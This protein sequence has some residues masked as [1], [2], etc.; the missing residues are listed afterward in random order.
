MNMMNNRQPPN[1]SAGWFQGAPL[2]KFVCLSVI[3][4]HVLLEK[5]GFS[6]G[7]DLIA[8]GELYVILRIFMYQVCFSMFQQN[9]I[10]SAC[11]AGW[12]YCRS[13]RYGGASG[14]VQ[15][16]PISHDIQISQ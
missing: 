15:T 10:F 11:Y 4:G 14:I 8:L 3:L 2:T 5:G 12:Y 16:P 13:G 7:T 6:G 1:A 9:L